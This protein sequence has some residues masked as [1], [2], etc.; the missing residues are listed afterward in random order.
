MTVLL[1]LPAA[2]NFGPFTHD[3]RYVLARHG[4]SLDLGYYIG[5]FMTTFY[6]RLFVPNG[7][8]IIPNSFILIMV[9]HHSLAILMYVPMNIYYPQFH[10]LA[11][12][13]VYVLGLGAVIVGLIYF[14]T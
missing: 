6:T 13:C 5:H 11:D 1:C 2:F 4:Y 12:M 10:P 3:Q 14:Y 9:L 7:D 8:K